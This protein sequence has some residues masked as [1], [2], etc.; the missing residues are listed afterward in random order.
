[1]FGSEVKLTLSAKTNVQKNYLNTIIELL[2]V[3][4]DTTSKPY[5]IDIKLLSALNK[6]TQTSNY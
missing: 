6:Q 2:L 3:E 4:R 1:M 5:I